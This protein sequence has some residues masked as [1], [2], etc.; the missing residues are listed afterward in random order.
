[1]SATCYE[2]R[3]RCTLRRLQLAPLPSY[4]RFSGTILSHAGANASGARDSIQRLAHRRADVEAPHRKP[5]NGDRFDFSSY[6]LVRH[7]NISSLRS[8]SAKVAESPSAVRKKRWKIAVP[9]ALLPVAALIAGGLYYRSHQSKPLIPLSPIRTVSTVLA[10][11][12]GVQVA[13]KSLRIHWK[14]F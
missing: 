11:K 6:A 4:L 13:C 14:G 8:R 3:A 2:A 10:T 5:S 7:L 12:Q 9:G 1:M